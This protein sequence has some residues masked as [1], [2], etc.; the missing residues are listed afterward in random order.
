MALQKRIF[1]SNIPLRHRSRNIFILF[2]IIPPANI[3]VDNTEKNRKSNGEK[4]YSARFYIDL[5][6][7]FDALHI[8]GEAADVHDELAM[9]HWEPLQGGSD[10]F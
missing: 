1:I 8:A 5:R 3:A 6:L 10:E 7:C 2:R 9:R 4:R